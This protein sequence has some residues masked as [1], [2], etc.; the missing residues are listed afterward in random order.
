MYKHHITLIKQQMKTLKNLYVIAVL[1]ITA[2]LASCSKSNDAKPAIG[3]LTNSA[4]LFFANNTS[5]KAD[6]NDAVPATYIDGKLKIN[7]GSSSNQVAI[8]IDNYDINADAKDYTN[9]SAIVSITQNVKTY[10]SSNI[11]IPVIAGNPPLPVYVTG[12]IITI[13]ATNLKVDDHTTDVSLLIT[14]G[15]VLI[16]KPSSDGTA[17]VYGTMIFALGEGGKP[18]IITVRIKH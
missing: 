6:G 2:S 17:P 12:K 3:E 10:N 18:N 7:F 15:S 14:S 11:F 1:F 4:Q 5:I 8:E 16:T 13:N 9:G